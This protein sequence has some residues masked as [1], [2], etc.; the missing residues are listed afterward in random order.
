MKK[1]KPEEIDTY[2][3]RSIDKFTVYHNSTVELFNFSEII[4]YTEEIVLLKKYELC[5]MLL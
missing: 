5:L 2:K 4:P 3:S 1:M